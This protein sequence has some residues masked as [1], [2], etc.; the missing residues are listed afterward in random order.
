VLARLAEAG[1]DSGGPDDPLTFTP[2]YVARS[3][4]EEKSGPPA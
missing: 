4:A 2:L 3:Q 1:L